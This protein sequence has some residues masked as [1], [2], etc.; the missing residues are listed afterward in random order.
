MDSQSIKLLAPLRPYPSGLPAAKPKSEPG[1][2]RIA[3]R[4]LVFA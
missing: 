1:F 2:M 3:G 4:T